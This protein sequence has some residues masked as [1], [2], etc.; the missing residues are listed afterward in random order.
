M[1]VGSTSNNP[2]TVGSRASI[3]RNLKTLKAPEEGSTKKKYEDLLDKVQNHIAI[4][5]DFGKDIGHLLKHMED[6]TLPE[7]T[8]MT[9]AEEA[10]KWE[11]RLW[12]QEVERYRDRGAVLEGNKGALYAVLVDGVSKIIKSDLKN[13]TG[14]SKA[15]GANDS[16][17]LLQTLEDIL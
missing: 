11:V 1:S 5:W 4:S 13:K 2:N 12:R 14:Y 9:A 15:D 7:P 10:V 6:Q 17:W 8:Y 3:V 16:V